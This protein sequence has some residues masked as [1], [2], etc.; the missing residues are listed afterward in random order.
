MDFTLLAGQL[1]LTGIN[2]WELMDV[3]RGCGPC[4][5]LQSAPSR[6]QRRLPTVLSTLAFK[7]LLGVSF[8]V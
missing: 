4:A 1:P 8:L 7:D 5:G 2:V 6:G 3:K